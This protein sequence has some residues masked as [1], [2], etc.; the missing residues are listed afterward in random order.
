M[1][2]YGGTFQNTLYSEYQA[3]PAGNGIGHYPCLMWLPEG[4][5][6]SVGAGRTRNS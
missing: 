4:L 2:G 6:G 3:F 1:K 5:D